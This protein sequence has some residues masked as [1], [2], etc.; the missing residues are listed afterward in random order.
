LLRVPPTPGNHSHIVTGDRLLHTV[1][2]ATYVCTD[3]G[4][5]EQWINSKAE[6]ASLKAAW[7]RQKG[8]D[9]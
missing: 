2:T 7:V 9:R 1:N 3:C 5:V 4:H 6:L 8:G